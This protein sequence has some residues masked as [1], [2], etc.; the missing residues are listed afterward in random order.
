MPSVQA[1]ALPPRTLLSRY[2]A[3][4]AFTDCYV[5]ELP[6]SVAHSEFVEALYFGTLMRFERKLIG[7]LLSKPTS[8][9]HVRELA[10]GNAA[11]FAAWHVEE[12]TPS[13]LLLQDQTGRT[14][15]WLMSQAVPG[16]TRLYFGSALLPRVHPKTGARHMGPLFKPLLGF[17]ALYSKLLLSSA[18]SR[19]ERLSGSA[20]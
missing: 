19:L 5:T 17:H 7:W 8:N 2:A 1:C 4:G 18:R 15:S 14:R 3:D 6:K 9:A 16:A 11:S 10:T 12:R 20:P 13:E